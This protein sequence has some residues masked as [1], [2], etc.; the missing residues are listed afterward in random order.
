MI[1]AI[2]FD[3]FGVL[4]RDWWK[5][6]CSTLPPGPVLDKAKQLNHQ[7]DAGLLSIEDFVK[8]LVETTGREPKPIEGIFTSPESEKNIELFNYIKQ[9]KKEYKI[10]IL[11]NVGTSW[12]KEVFL[13]REEQT[14]F[15]ALVFSYEVG[16]TK[17]NPKIF[18]ISAEKLEVEPNECVLI[19]DQPTYCKV[20]VEV[21]MKSVVYENFL[22]MKA[23]LEEILSASS[24][25]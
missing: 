1:K 15:S 13:T 22:Q 7:Y 4:T 17:P 12:I 9:L 18:Q 11:S 14:L 19:D 16:I 3:C 10:A 21:G 8:A 5:E 23:D 2:I 6:F 20:A 25:N 24:N